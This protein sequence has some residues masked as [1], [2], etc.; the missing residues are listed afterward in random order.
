MLGPTAHCMGG[1][2]QGRVEQNLSTWVSRTGCPV[3]EAHSQASPRK[4]RLVPSTWAREAFCCPFPTPRKT[5]GQHLTAGFIWSRCRGSSGRSR[6]GQV[7]GA[8]ATDLS[9]SYSDQSLQ[10]E[11][12][13][14]GSCM[15]FRDTEALVKCHK[16][17][18]WYP[19]AWQSTGSLGLGVSKNGLQCQPLGHRL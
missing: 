17:G 7:G 15:A 2:G 10:A 12:Q 1:A 3:C 5:S 8:T 9:R 19:D 11:Q 18:T 16:P 6:R 14:S 13:S 4:C